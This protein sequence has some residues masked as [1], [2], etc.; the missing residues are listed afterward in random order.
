MIVLWSY[1][2]QEI[3]VESQQIDTF[4]MYVCIKGGMEEFR[5]TCADKSLK[6]SKTKKY[7]KNS[8][9]KKWHIIF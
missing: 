7:V 9:K 4:E 3:T 5:K 6:C 2:L 8:H 1:K